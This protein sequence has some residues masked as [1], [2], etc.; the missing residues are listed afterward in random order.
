MAP[1]ETRSSLEN[2]AR[3][4]AAFLERHKAAV[5][6]LLSVVYAVGAVGQARGKPLWY[7]EIITTISAAAPDAATTWKV[8]RQTD[9]NPPLP[10]LLTHFT[11]KWVANE[12]VGTRIPAMAGFWIF[13]LCLYRFTLRRAG[14]FY[15]LAALLLPVVTSA[16]GFALEARAYGPVLGFCGLALAG[17]QSAADGIKRPLA[18]AVL[19]A[20]LAA[21][22]LSHYYAILIYLPLAGGEA[23]R[24][25]RRRRLDWPVWAAFAAGGIP[26]VWS[27][28]TIVT[29]ASRWSA[30]SWAPP[31]VGQVWEFWEAGLQPSLIFLV[32][33]M[34]LLALAIVAGRQK[35]DGLPGCAVALEDHELIAGVLF[36]AIPAAAVAGAMLVT[37][38][39]TPRYA[40]FALA[41][42]G[43]L[44]PMLTAHLSGGRM[45][46][47][48]LM[49]VT[50]LAALGLAMIQMPAPQ[51][52]FQQEPMLTKVLPREQVVIPDGQLFL[53]VWHYAPESQKSHLLFVADGTAALKYVGYDSI[54]EGMRVVR[55]FAPVQVVDYQ[56]FYAP[57]KEFLIYQNTMRPGWLLE[58][59]LDD[60]GSAQV[61]ASSGFRELIRVRFKP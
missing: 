44:A 52:P 11:M 3:N 50:L 43:F 12:E 14:I 4:L 39:F 56:A 22:L 54:D 19:A 27:A 51:N 26:L 1:T 61:L 36:L 53:L 55:P 23:F 15:A 18:L 20:G 34:A 41:G 35:A 32:M 25:Y 21:A 31:S 57:G 47:G 13:S 2:D 40:L 49:T 60:G 24:W 28:A 9:L 42:F 16:Y 45:L 33:L 5:L 7:D 8:A 38:M 17:W 37:H 46:P 6:I 29:G 48:F 58:K 10:H 30:H 59:V